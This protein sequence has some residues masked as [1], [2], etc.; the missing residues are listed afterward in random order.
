V[1]DTS[2]GFEKVIGNLQEGLW[3]GSRGKELRVDVWS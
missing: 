3:P 2:V 1:R